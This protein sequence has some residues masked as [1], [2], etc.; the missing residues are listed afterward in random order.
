VKVTGLQRG[1]EELKLP[2][3]GVPGPIL[4]IRTYLGGTG[5]MLPREIF[6]LYNAVNAFW[7]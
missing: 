7:G 4:M 5:G 3:R 2:V 6:V 1:P